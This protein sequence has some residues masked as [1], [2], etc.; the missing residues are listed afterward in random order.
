VQVPGRLEVIARYPIVLRDAA[1]NPDSART[2]ARE[3]PRALGGL[4][5]I[6]GLVALL[7]DKD[8]DG[9]LAA[10]APIFDEIVV[11][12]TASERALPAA[13][14]L[15]AAERHGLTGEAVADPED[16]LARA[17]YRAGNAGA[18]VIVG[19]LTLLEALDR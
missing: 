18:V 10:L 13:T 14:L 17:R 1:H 3:L 4:K 16:A 9:F 7:A 6:V 19:S 15:A 8:A 5:P 11:T 12:A 2:L